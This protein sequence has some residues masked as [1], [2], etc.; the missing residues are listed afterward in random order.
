MDDV[1]KQC[2]VGPEYFEEYKV[3]YSDAAL[4]SIRNI[5]IS[6]LILCP[7]QWLISKKEAPD[8]SA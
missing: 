2:G 1:C 7:A 4:L 8:P 5:G 3:Y 6:V